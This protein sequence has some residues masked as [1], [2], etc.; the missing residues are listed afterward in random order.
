VQLP[1]KEQVFD[2]DFLVSLN[3]TQGLGLFV[4]ET[5]AK[6]IIDSLS[7]SDRPLTKQ[8]ADAFAPTQH[9]KGHSLFKQF[10][11]RRLPNLNSNILKNFTRKRRFRPPFRLI[12]SS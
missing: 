12:P 7:G 6:Y 11:Q 8:M 2:A 9:P 1:E 5:E 4:I 3:A 10:R